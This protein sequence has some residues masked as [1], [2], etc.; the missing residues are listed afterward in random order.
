VR[1]RTRNRESRGVDSINSSA[2]ILK[3]QNMTMMMTTITKEESST[4]VLSRCR[5]SV[6]DNST[7]QNFEIRR[8]NR[9]AHTMSVNNFS[10]CKLEAH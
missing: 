9:E 8:L 7:R 6:V 4:M 10:P 5:P 2:K 1:V 3:L